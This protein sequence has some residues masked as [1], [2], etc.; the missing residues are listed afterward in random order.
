MISKLYFRV[1]RILLTL[2]IDISNGFEYILYM[3]IHILSTPIQGASS[4]K[5][6][7][8]CQLPPTPRS[9]V[10]S[11]CPIYDAI[12]WR[13]LQSTIH[14][15]IC[16]IKFLIYVLWLGNHINIYTKVRENNKTTEQIILCMTCIIV[17]QL[18]TIARAREKKEKKRKKN[19]RTRRGHIA[20]THSGG[21]IPVCI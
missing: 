10:S 21:G 17:W 16:I 3:S 14:T 11:S 13:I 12:F 7:F 5:A 20:L 4:P 2:F 8:Y 6:L 15:H 9:S 1:L 19:H 18:I